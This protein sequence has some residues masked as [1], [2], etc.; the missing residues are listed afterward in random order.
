MDPQLL[1][2]VLTP[3]MRHGSWGDGHLYK[4]EKKSFKVNIQAFK[5]T[6]RTLLK[7]QPC[8][9][10]NSP[11]TDSSFSLTNSEVIHTPGGGFLI[12]ES[13]QKYQ[14]S[15]QR[16]LQLLIAVTVSPGYSPINGDPWQTKHPRIT[17]LKTFSAFHDLQ[18]YHKSLVY[19]L[20]RD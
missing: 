9:V 6:A 14:S 11:G 7:R 10:E 18:Y 2:G 12:V 3:G 4:D 20:F 1:K 8:G 16:M 17:L 13:R 19:I 15:L 5:F